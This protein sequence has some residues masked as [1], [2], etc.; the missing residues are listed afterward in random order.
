[1]HAK[2]LQLCLTL[3]DLLTVA[4][5][6]PLSMGVLPAGILEWVAMPF[7]MGSSRPM[8]QTCVSCG[9]CVAG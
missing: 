3:W 6:A 1:M 8:D 5:Q 2:S 7:S 4:L 9:S